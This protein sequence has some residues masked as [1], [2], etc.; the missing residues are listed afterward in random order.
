MID[1][2]KEFVNTCDKCELAKRTSNLRSGM[3][4]MKSIPICDLFY[5][6]AF[7]TT[8][9]LP[10]TLNGNKYMLVAIYH[11]FKW[12]ETRL[13]KSCDVVIVARFLEEEVVCCFGL[14]KYVFTN[15]GSEWM[16]EFD[17]LC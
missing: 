5:R 4:D 13:V 8:R 17:V 1:S 12:C 15:N 14:P 9:P 3:D 16:K 11:Y 7:D 10:K 6:I 2:I